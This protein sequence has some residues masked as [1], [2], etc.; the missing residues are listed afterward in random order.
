MNWRPANSYS[1][2]PTGLFSAPSAVSPLLMYT[3]A[4][5]NWF[6]VA[7][8]ETGKILYEIHET[9]PAVDWGFDSETGDAVIVFEDG[10]A[11]CADIFASPEELYA[12][13]RA[14][15]QSLSKE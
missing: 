9:R 11:R 12:A 3:N 8:V 6:C 14:Q 13:A 2:Q 4:P 15:R 10:S 1:H 5:K 7:S